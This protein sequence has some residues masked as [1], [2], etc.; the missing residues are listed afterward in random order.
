MGLS[1][2]WDFWAPILSLRCDPG[3]EL[4]PRRPSTAWCFRL[5]TCPFVPKIYCSPAGFPFS[6]S[7]MAWWSSSS[8]SQ[9]HMT[10]Y[11]EFS[12]PFPNHNNHSRFRFFQSVRS[13]ASYFRCREPHPSSHLNTPQTITLPTARPPFLALSLALLLQHRRW[14]AKSVICVVHC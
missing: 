14:R 5:S 2:C 7:P 3:P 6:T 13:Q 1:T 9:H 10:P 12:S 8:Y 4:K 11:H